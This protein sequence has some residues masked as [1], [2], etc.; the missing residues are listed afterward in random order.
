[1]SL[2]DSRACARIRLFS[3]PR[4]N[5]M[6]DLADRI[7]RGVTTNPSRGGLGHTIETTDL[8]FSS[9]MLLPGNNEAI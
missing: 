4:A 6:V 9:N 8:D 3:L 1:M 2:G 7:T 5:K